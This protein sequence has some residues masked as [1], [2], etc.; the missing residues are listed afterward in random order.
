MKTG[1]IIQ[2]RTS[3]TRLPQK[4][5]KELPYGSG[6]TV[7]QQVIR[8]LRKSKK[9]NEI[10]IAT[11]TDREDKKIVKVAEDENV[12]WFR[13]SKDDVLGRYYSAAKENNLD[14]IVRITSDCP[15]IDLK[16]VDLVLEKHITSNSDYTSNCLKISFPHGLDTEVISFNALKEANSA[17]KEDFEREHVT[18]YIYKTKP[19]LFKITSVKAPRKFN[20]PDIRITLDTEEDYAL[21]CTVYDYLYSKNKFFDTNNIIEL[22]KTKPWLK[23][24]NKKIIQKK[25]FTTL[26][27]E[28]EEA[29]K[30]C[31][32]QDLKKT[33][34]ILDTFKNAEYSKRKNPK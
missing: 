13:G 20:F 27:E 28:I 14:I 15:C 10:I 2:A 12:K 5:L 3:S 11:T 1:A 33:K 22:F 6:I 31:D 24:I 25:I 34:E 9:L 21:L 32:S 23:L 29:I 7:L 8:R 4:V 26:E 17:A 30:L 16:V 18:P 19:D